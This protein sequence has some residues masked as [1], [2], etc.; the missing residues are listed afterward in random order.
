MRHVTSKLL[1][2]QQDHLGEI[3][4]NK[5]PQALIWESS[6]Y[7]YVWKTSLR[8]TFLKSSRCDSDSSEIWHPFVLMNSD[9]LCIVLRN[10]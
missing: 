3:R 4:K 5:F 6:I 2:A 8:S 10:R 7:K 1:L 9:V